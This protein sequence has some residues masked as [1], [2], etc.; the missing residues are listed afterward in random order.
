MGFDNLFG[1]FPLLFVQ[2][3]QCF[4]Q[5]FSQGDIDGVAASN[6]IIRRD[7]GRSIGQRDRDGR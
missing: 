5:S 3:D 7:N 1:P 4:T 6:L 2:G